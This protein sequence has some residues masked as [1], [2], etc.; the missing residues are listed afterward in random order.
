MLKEGLGLVNGQRQAADTGGFAIVNG[1][2]EDPVRQGAD[3][4]GA[5]QT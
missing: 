1:R 4:F 3:G 5:T 2:G